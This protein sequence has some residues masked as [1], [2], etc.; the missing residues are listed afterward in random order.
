MDEFLFI[1]KLKKEK[2]KPKDNKKESLE[3]TIT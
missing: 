3:S 1:F 2:K